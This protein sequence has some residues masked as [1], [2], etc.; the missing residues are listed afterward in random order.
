M[1]SATRPATSGSGA[2]ADVG[3]VVAVDESE[4]VGKVGVNDI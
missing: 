2:G 4:T 3:P 1:R